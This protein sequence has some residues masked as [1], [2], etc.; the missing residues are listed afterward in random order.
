MATGVALDRTEHDLVGRPGAEDAALT[1]TRCGC[2]WQ[3]IRDLCSMP[4]P[5]GQRM[6]VARLRT[7]D[8]QA[9]FGQRLGLGLLELGPR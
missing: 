8:D 6:R 9:E 4:F 1:G 7:R 2:G 5:K 3:M